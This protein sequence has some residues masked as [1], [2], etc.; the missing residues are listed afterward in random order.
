MPVSRK[1][2]L[3]GH[4]GRGVLIGHNPCTLAVGEAPDGGG[5]GDVGDRRRHRCRIRRGA[6]STE[7]D[8][9]GVS[10]AAGFPSI[11]GAVHVADGGPVGVVV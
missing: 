1:T 3:D 8:V 9:H 2:H 7:V 6:A 5:S 11:T 4:V 10:P